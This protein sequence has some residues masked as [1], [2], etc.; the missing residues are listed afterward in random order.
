MVSLD[1]VILKRR[2]RFLKLA[3]VTFQEGANACVF[4]RGSEP[5]LFRYKQLGKKIQTESGN[6]SVWLRKFDYVGW[7]RGWTAPGGSW[8]FF[9]ER[10]DL[11]RSS[12][13]FLIDGRTRSRAIATKPGDGDPSYLLLHGGSILCGPPS[14]PDLF[15]TL[16]PYTL[17]LSPSVCMCVFLCFSLSLFLSVSLSLVPS[18]RA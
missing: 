6:S 17:T 1:T 12:R 16:L 7:R 5:P 9:A 15:R 3:L 8:R 4:S 18:Q 14:S 2:D 13:S 10:S 11:R